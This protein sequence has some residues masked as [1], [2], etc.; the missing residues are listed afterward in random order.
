M[1]RPDGTPQ[2]STHPGD[3]DQGWRAKAC[4]VCATPLEGFLGIGFRL[5]G[6]SRSSRNPNLCSRC[7]THAEEG[8]LTQLTVLFADLTSFTELTHDLG[9]ERTHE[10]VHGFLQ[11]A[12]R[13]LT[14]HDAFIDK[15][16]GDAVMAF[17]NAPIAR[18]DHAAQAVAAARSILDGLPQLG[19]R[20]GVDLNASIGIA[21]GWARVGRLGSSDSKDYTAMGDVVNLAARLESAARSGEI[22]VEHD[23]Y[24]ALVG[25]E[26][27]APLELI[28]VKGF[29]E[30]VAIHRLNATAPPP[31]GTFSDVRPAQRALNL[32]G[33]IFAVLGA[34]CAAATLIGPLAVGLGFT[35][36]G[37]LG[38]LW[39]LENTP[40]RYPI[41]ALAALGALANLY[42]VWHARR[43]RQRTQAAGDALPQT[44]LERQRVIMLLGTSAVTIVIVG[45]EL[46]AH[47]HLMDQF[48]MLMP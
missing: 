34:P 19:D 46:Y 40:A 24:T 33:M 18:P 45:F 28:Q 37:F 7:S 6:I 17:F 2:P 20:F 35:S 23:V 1:A 11:M 42:T 29:S 26:S 43:F 22:A 32:G 13:A 12:S 36:L 31:I 44:R 14:D 41:L 16:V 5:A 8:R 10:V 21:S 38:A 48:M 3:H 9:P 25:E 47:E 4:V 27:A 30:P 39:S 15:Y